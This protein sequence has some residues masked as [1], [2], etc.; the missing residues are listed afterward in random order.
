MEVDDFLAHY[1]VKGMKWGVRKQRAS[2]PVVSRS[3][4]RD[5][6]PNSDGSIDIPRGAHIQRVVNGKRL[7]SKAGLD[8]G[9]THTYASFTKGDN[10]RYESNFGIISKGVVED[11]RS[12]SGSGSLQSFLSSKR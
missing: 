8:I 11:S 9:E 3:S 7:L 4:P 2:T 12:F 6:K 5:L 10:L 1:G